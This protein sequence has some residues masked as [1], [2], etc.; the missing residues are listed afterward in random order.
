MGKNLIG[1]KKVNKEIAEI[2][3][4]AVKIY[5]DF[6]CTPEEALETAR[7]LYKSNE[8]QV[9]KTDRRLKTF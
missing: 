7:Y 3:R 4:E 5:F 1:V 9:E 2:A 8:I 6:N